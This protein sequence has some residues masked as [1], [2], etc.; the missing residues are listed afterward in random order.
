MT[1]VVN[2][3]LIKWEGRKRTERALAEPEL[4]DFGSRTTS[5][6]IICGAA[7]AQESMR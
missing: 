3:K 5:S 1:P 4:E 6:E 7:V 2:A